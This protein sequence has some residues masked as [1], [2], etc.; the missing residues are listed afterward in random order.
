M[1]LE[2]G[3]P[4]NPDHDDDDDIQSLST[5]VA[6]VLKKPHFQIIMSKCL[7]FAF[8]PRKLWHL[9]DSLRAGA[10][11]AINPAFVT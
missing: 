2:V 1:T 5:F 10:C 6:F 11:S 4:L 8:L 7:P 9:V 3:A